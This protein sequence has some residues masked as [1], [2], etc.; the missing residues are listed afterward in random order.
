MKKIIFSL[1]AVLLFA[2]S[3][4]CQ[5]TIDVEKEKEA[6]KAI[7]EEAT[8]AWV[9]RDLDRLAATSVTDET[10]NRLIAGKSGFEYAIGWKDRA[11]SAKKIFA[12]NPN[13]N[14]VKFENKNYKIKVYPKSA[15]AVYEENWYDSVGEY[16][17]MSINVRFLEKVNEEWKIV[18]L[19]VINTT[20]YENDDDD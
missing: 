10:F 9:E 18:Y 3:A 12:D 15:W 4:Y 8:S 16:L 14:A 5:G 13:P 7:I 1:F 6:I 11:A 17:G 20:S 2:G 19:S